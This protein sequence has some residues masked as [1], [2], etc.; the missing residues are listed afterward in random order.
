MDT[1]PE[2]TLGHGPSDRQTYHFLP[3]ISGHF[4][5]LQEA[6]LTVNCPHGEHS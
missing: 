5:C 2:G 1:S 4:G 6:G 3:V